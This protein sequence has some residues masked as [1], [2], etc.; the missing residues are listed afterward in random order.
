MAQG[1]RSRWVYVGAAALLAV[2]TWIDWASGYELE[3]FAFYF[4]PVSLAAWYG[5]RRGGLVLAAASG[6]CWYLSDRLSHHPYPHPLLGYWETLM[7]L[8]AYTIIALALARLRAQ[9]EHQ[10]DLLRAVSHDLRTP[11][12]A[13][14]GQA[15]LLRARQEAG[16]W[17]ALR[18][19][20]ILRAAHRMDAMIDDLLGAAR[21]R[22]RRRELDLRPVE[23]RPFLDELL[24]RMAPILECSRVELELPVGERLAIGADPARLER[25]VVNLLSNALRYAPPPT[26]VQVRAARVG[27]RAVLSVI[28]HGPGI[29]PGDRRHLFERFYR[30][31]AS[32]GTEG[33]GL[34][35]HGT[36]LLVEA[37]GGRI[38][39]EGTPGG[40]ASF[41]VEMPAAVAP[42]PAGQVAGKT[43]AAV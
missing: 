9:A 14:V 37:H 8:V 30:G 20:A 11:L 39:V 5:S 34:G 41:H 1:T 15:Q 21:R 24:A 26:R 38:R 13:V 22:A 35:L 31:A 36:R 43:T 19:E 4:V 18:A 27:S 10:R 3:L 7:R 6:A 33:L 12:T 23:L 28:D 2:I 25:I 17:G 32:A 29:A 42:P 16:S 40:G